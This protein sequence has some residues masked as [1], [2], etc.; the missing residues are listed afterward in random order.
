MQNY[1]GGDF[2][3]FPKDVYSL[4]TRS[5]VDLIPGAARCQQNNSTVLPAAYYRGGTSKA[6]ISNED[7]TSRDEKG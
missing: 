6:V 1:V 2:Y 5:S 4:R 7:N 3:I